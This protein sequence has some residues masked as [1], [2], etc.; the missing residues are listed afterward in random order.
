MADELF[1]PLTMTCSSIGIGNTAI[2]IPL[3]GHAGDSEVPRWDHPLGAGGVE[4]T[5]GDLARYAE[6]CLHPPKAKLGAAINA[7]LATQLEVGDGRHQ[8]LAWQ[9]RDDGI[10]GQDGGTAGFSSAVLID[11]GRDRAVAMLASYGG[12]YA[13]VL[14]HAG[15]LA[16]AGD[17]PR[18]ALPQPP[19]PEWDARARDVIQ[20]LVDER[21]EDIH[22]RATAAIRNR[23][24]AEQLARA[25][26]SV[27]QDL[28]PVTDVVVSRKQPGG[29]V[30]ADATI[31]F[32]AGTVALRIGFEQTGKI[33]GLRLL[34][35]EET[36]PE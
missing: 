21:A 27:T 22:A 6:A 8:A 32:A 24:S 34:P 23:L 3:P 16:L 2:A 11:P 17:D 31:T 14:G 1:G 25:W 5:I 7:A 9:I 26:R 4:A 20:S 12:G 29:L 35:P 33:A 28:G 18:A 10:R 19:G 36:L 30:V 15:L 13:R